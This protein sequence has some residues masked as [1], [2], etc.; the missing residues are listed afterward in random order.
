MSGND[1]S[2]KALRQKKFCLIETLGSMSGYPLASP[3]I[4]A[5]NSWGL[6]KDD[7][8]SWFVLCLNSLS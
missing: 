1:R 8:E 6:H 5:H 4:V 2:L 3:D 7:P